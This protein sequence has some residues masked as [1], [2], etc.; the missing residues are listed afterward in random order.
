MS[1]ALWIPAGSLLV[2]LLVFAPSAQ[3]ACASECTEVSG[4]VCYVENLV[5]VCDESC[6]GCECDRKCRCRNRCKST[7]KYCRRLAKAGDPWRPK[8]SREAL[9]SD[10]RKRAW[11]NCLRGP[12]PECSAGGGGGHALSHINTPVRRMILDGRAPASGH[13][14]LSMRVSLRGPQP[15][16]ALPQPS[17]GEF[18]L[19]IG[20]ATFHP[21]PPPGGNVLLA[22]A[23][24]ASRGQPG[25]RDEECVLD[26]EIPAAEEA[27]PI[28]LFFRSRDASGLL[29]KTPTTFRQAELAADIQSPGP[30]HWYRLLRIDSLPPLEP[31]DGMQVCLDFAI[32]SRN[33]ASLDPT[34]LMGAVELGINHVFFN[35]PSAVTCTDP[36]SGVRECR[37]CFPAPT[38]AAGRAAWFL[39]TDANN[40]QIPDLDIMIPTLD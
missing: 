25:S 38:G 11:K 14:F 40:G 20:K 18:A 15:G 5:V 9:D 1:I 27:V 6:C 24:A 17:N 30:G 35:A 29:P 32:W 21:I 3:A 31:N 34:T 4:C 28:S 16:G 26:F 23:G 13:T 36:V 22:C 37:F 2:L 39:P 10:C 7:Y 19:R 33:G 8:L 12:F